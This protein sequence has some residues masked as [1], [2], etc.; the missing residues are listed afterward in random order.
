[1]NPLVQTPL[2]LAAAVAAAAWLLPEAEA[3][4]IQSFTQAELFLEL[5]DTDGDLGLHASLDAGGWTSLEIEGPRGVG[6]LL[7]ITTHRGLRQQGM[8]QL[9]FESTEP[10]FDELSPDEFLER[11]PEGR[12]AIEARALDGSAM[13]GVARVSHV[14]AAPPGNILLSTVPAAASCDE[15]PPLVVPPVVI[16]WDAVTRSHPDLGRS[17]PVSISR[18]EVIVEGEGFSWSVE[19]P[20]LVTEIEVPAGIISLGTDFKFEIVARTTAGNNTAVESCFQVQ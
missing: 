12:Y 20:P 1:M 9:D 18:Y 16:R 17:G 13:R 3:Q 14:L 2:V 15:P 19:L 7:S 8:T 11:F 10:P 5:N 4:R 6:P